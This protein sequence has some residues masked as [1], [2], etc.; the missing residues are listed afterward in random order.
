MPEDGN[1]HAFTVKATYKHVCEHH[2]A[3]R[4]ARTAF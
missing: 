4:M 1:S 2:E 3:M